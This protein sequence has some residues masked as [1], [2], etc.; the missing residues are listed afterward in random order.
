MPAY[1][2]Q[3]E[4][5]SSGIYHGWVT[6]HPKEAVVMRYRMKRLFAGLLSAVILL[7]LLPATAWAAGVFEGA[8][9]GDGSSGAPYQIS[10][11]EQLRQLSEYVNGGKDCTGLF[12]KLTADIDLGGEGNQW[13][14]IGNTNNRFNGSFDGGNH[15][16]CVYIDSPVGTIKDLGFFGYIDTN[17]AVKNLGVS[18]SIDGSGIGDSYVGGIAGQNYG[19][20]GGGQ[21]ISVRCFPIRVRPS[22]G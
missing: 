1:R 6:R 19:N 13:T 12:F 8:D 15:T 4:R 2:F 9:S 10:T 20:R 7:S 16:V 17:G 3:A 5:K 22:I 18:G 14:P 21:K 11:A